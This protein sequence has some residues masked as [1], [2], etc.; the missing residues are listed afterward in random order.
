MAQPPKHQGS[1]LCGGVRFEI[2]GPLAPIQI[3]YCS[4]C[5][6]AQGGPL[7]SNIPVKVDQ[8]TWLAGRDLL[9]E[10]ESSPG[11]LR[12]FCSH[13]GSPVYSARPSKPE[14]LRIRAGLLD[15]PVATPVELHQHLASRC[16][17]WPEPDDE[18]PHF[19]GPK[20]D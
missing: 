1:C 18:L 17:W 10:Y 11:K 19:D 5:R 13:C 8:L 4:Q 9:R 20:H 15:E 2:A 16:S 12:A 7:G 14:V 6:K 3:C